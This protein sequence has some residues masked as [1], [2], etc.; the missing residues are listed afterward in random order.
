MPGEL[1]PLGNKGEHNILVHL[2][3]LGPALIRSDS[4]ETVKLAAVDGEKK[5]RE[6]SASRVEA[7]STSAPRLLANLAATS[8]SSPRAVTEVAVD[9]GDVLTWG[10]GAASVCVCALT[11]S[12]PDSGLASK[13]RATP[14]AVSPGQFQRVR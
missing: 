5:Q 11:R 8:F 2:R 6:P 14:T 4:R 3:A 13:T 12:K 10:G 7:D 1:K 9:T